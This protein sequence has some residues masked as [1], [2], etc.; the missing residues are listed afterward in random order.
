VLAL[1]WRQPTEISVK[2]APA[3]AVMAL[4][5]VIGELVN[6]MVEAKDEPA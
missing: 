5:V 3:P 1:Q 4:F 6:T 2:E